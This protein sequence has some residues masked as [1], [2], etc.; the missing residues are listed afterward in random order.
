MW[1]AGGYFNKQRKYMCLWE[2]VC[3]CVCIWEG[4]GTKERGIIVP[5]IYVMLHFIAA[6][7][8]N[9]NNPS[10][11]CHEHTHTLENMHDTCKYMCSVESWVAAVPWCSRS[12]FQ[13][14]LEPI[15][16]WS[17]VKGEQTEQRVSKQAEPEKEAWRLRSKLHSQGSANLPSYSKDDEEDTPESCPYLRPFRPPHRGTQP[18]QPAY[19]IQGFKSTGVALGN[20][21]GCKCAS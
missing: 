21:W 7:S 13:S 19:F 17:D 2:S 8:I 9:N 10:K 16:H 3:G 6:P 18:W 4:E 15:L 14:V 20:E 5:P 1:T 12:F 11:R